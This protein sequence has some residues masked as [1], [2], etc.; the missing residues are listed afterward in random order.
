MVGSRD[1]TENQARGVGR[2][3]RGKTR[4]RRADG[5][6]TETPRR[7]GT[8]AWPSGRMPVVTPAGVSPIGCR[9]AVAVRG[10]AK[11]GAK[12]VLEG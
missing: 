1:E 8:G 12:H 2:L 4:I 10:A 7:R 9:P 5:F 11:I 6:A 3:A